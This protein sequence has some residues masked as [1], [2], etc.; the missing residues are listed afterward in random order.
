MILVQGGSK[1]FDFSSDPKDPLS[2][3]IYGFA[4]SANGEVY[5]G[6]FSGVF[7]F[8]EKTKSFDNIISK[9]MLSSHYNG[10][11]TTVRRLMVD[12]KDNLWIGTNKSLLQYSKKR[13]NKVQFY[14]NGELIETPH[15]HY[16]IYHRRF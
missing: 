2:S 5:A 16:S 8:S 3:P 7:K 1:S 9:P 6:G 4:E 14:E 10:Q 15:L 11:R 12:S 13:L